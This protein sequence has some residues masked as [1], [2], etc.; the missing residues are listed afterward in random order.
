MSI[1]IPISPGELVDKITILEIKQEKIESEQKRRNVSLELSLL[2][3]RWQNTSGA[4][5]PQVAAVRN[6]LKSINE[7]LWDIEDRI[8]LLEAAQDFG[9][10]FIELARSVY[11]T[12]D[13]RAAAKREIN[14]LLGSNIIEEKDY[15]DYQQTK[16]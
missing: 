15:V 6:T 1:E 8:R 4:S 3:A 7:Q 2:N 11:I 14:N 13:K 16:T 9:P 10:A 5:H 12:N